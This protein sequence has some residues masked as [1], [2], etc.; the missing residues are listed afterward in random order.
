LKI[1]LYEFKSDKKKLKCLCG[2]ERTVKTADLP[3]VYKKF[4][5]HCAQEARPPLK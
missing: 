5:E 4:A 1:H 2:W 3:L